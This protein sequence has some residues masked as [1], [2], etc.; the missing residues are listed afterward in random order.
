[1]RRKA[2]ILVVG[3]GPNS[4]GGVWSVLSTLLGSDLSRRYELRHV[5]THRD[6]S[7][8]DKLK[9][10][11]GGYLRI[12]IQ[13]VTNRPDAVWINTS[14]NASFRR[15]SIAMALTAAFGVPRVVHVHAGEF[16][17]YYRD[18]SPPEQ[19]LIRWGLGGAHR[20]VALTQTWKTVLDDI[21]GGDAVVVP[22]PVAVPESA[23]SSTPGTVVF[24]G[25]YGEQKGTPTLVRAF[26]QVASE[27]PDAR[28]IAAGDG[29]RE[30]AIALAQE[31]GVADRFEANGWLAHA[32]G[33]A[34]LATASVFVLPSLE[35]GLPVALLEAMAAGAPVIASAVG[36]IPDIVEEGVHGYLIPP[37]DQAALA[38]ALTE[39]FADPASAE[40]MGAAARAHIAATCGVPVVVDKLDE[41]L[42]AAVTRS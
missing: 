29:D 32:E 5:A 17:D 23:G 11:L 35:E 21:S 2:R 18:A 8:S 14:A 40:R 4:A 6:G 1:M 7:G 41:A 22:N 36:G 10:A 19:A 37:A 27:F 28:L 15:K 16:A 26:A 34:L 25:R 42:R 24:L 9:A 39:V 13:L 33:Q 3:P 31:L 38:R 20:V 30:G 12:L